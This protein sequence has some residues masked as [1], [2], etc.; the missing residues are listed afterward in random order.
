MTP[1]EF[2]PAIPGSERPQTHAS[3][4]DH[5]NRNFVVVIII[6]IIIIIIIPKTVLQDKL[7]Q[8]TTIAVS[9]IR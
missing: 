3:D 1:A 9:L 6:I 2:E 8:L 7:K 5:W 4:R